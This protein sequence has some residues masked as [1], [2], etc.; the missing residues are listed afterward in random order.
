M[1]RNACPSVRDFPYHPTSLPG[2]A[3]PVLGLAL[4]RDGTVT[5]SWCEISHNAVGVLI[6]LAGLDGDAFFKQ[7]ICHTFL[8][9]SKDTL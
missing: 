2:R 8:R 7:S 9:P 1:L 3:V 6:Y 4:V 5:Y